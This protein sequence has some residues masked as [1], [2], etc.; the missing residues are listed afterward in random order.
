MGFALAAAIGF[1]SASSSAQKKAGAAAE[2]EARRQAAEI[3]K[4]RFDVEE[5]AAQQHVDRM[6]SFSDLQR[7]NNAYAAFMGRSDR[8]IAALRNEEARRYGRDVDRIREQ[9]RREGVRINRE[10]EETVRQGQIAN[11]QY[12]SAARATMFNTLA[13]AAMMYN[14][15]GGKTTTPTPNTIGGGTGYKS[16]LDNPLAPKTQLA[17]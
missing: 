1:G 12:K 16:V 3:R 5:L 13:S 10:A 7:T 8:S 17:F 4:Q 6:M 9:E 11:K 2:A 15:P 14:A